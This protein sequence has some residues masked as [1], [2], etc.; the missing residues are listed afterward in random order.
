VVTHYKNTTYSNKIS[1]LRH[2][3]HL[4]QKCYEKNVYIKVA[5][6]YMDISILIIMIGFKEKYKYHFSFLKNF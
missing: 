6:T 1:F 2:R 5:N 3:I 4:D